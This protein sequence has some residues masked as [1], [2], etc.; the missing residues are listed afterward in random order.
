MQKQNPQRM[1]LR[2]ALLASV[3]CLLSLAPNQMNAQATAARSREA[4]VSAFAMFSRVWPDYDIPGNG[5]TFGADYTR[6]FKWASPSL[7][8]R[9]KKAD[10]RAVNER[11]FGGGIRVERSFSYFRPYADF[12]V[13][14]GTITFAGKNYI[15]AQGTGSNGSIVYSMGGGLDYD[16]SEQWA[17]SADY[18]HESWNVNKTPVVTLT[19]TALSFGLRYRFRLHRPFQ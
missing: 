7:E 6:F 14:S 19:P 1:V 16:F 13:S 8:A 3:L 2:L 18:Q 4:G 9:F 12:L 17:F 10:G 11:T 15:G 5:F